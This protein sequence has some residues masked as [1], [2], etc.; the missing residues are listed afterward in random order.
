MILST[1]SYLKIV[2]YPLKIVII[3]NKKFCTFD[4]ILLNLF[5]KKMRP[6]WQSLA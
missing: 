5:N 1:I 4:N 6:S 2:T 3:N